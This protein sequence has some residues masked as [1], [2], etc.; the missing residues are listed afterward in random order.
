VHARAIDAAGFIAEAAANLAGK[1]LL[2]GTT[3]EE[4]NAF[5][6]VDP[7]LEAPDLQLVA[8][9]FATLTGSA[10]NIEVYRRRQPGASQR[11]LLC[12][13]TTDSVFIQPTWD[14]RCPR[15]RAWRQRLGLPV[16]LGTPEFTI[17]GL[18]LHRAAVR[19]RHARRMEGGADAG[20]RRPGADAGPL[21]PRPPHLDRLRAQRRSGA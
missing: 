14:L 9:R 21:A 6:A 5:F 17:Q 20:R 19:F 4:M 10:A 12:D 16:R 3:R 2:I 18:P 11:D 13:L 15:C 7:A 1:P 8:Q